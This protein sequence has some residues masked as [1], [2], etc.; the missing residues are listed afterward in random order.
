MKQYARIFQYLKAYKGQVALYFLFTILSILFS[1]VSL[2]M[3]MPFLELIFYGEQS[4][5]TSTLMSGSSNPVVG[6]LRNF[7]LGTMEAAGGGVLGKV[8]TLGW[9]C[10]LILVSI[11]F[12]NF[13]LYLSYYILNPLKNRIVNSL[14]SDL[15]NK[16]LQ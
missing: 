12:K 14:R 6:A 4:S 5:S 11:F 7:L 15:Y 3:L 10:L 9:I 2:G 13:F 8:A 1:I 16:I